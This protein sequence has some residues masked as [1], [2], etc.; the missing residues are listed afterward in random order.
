MSKER[1]DYTTRDIVPDGMLSAVVPISRELAEETT[2]AAK[3]A[4]IVKSRFRAQMMEDGFRA[5][6][7]K[8]V[9]K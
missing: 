7:K 5:W 3:N 4:G 9:R 2:D 6:Q 8:Q 1:E